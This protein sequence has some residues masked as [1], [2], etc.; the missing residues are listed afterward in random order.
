MKSVCFY[1]RPTGLV[2][3]ITLPLYFILVVVELEKVLTIFHLKLNI[4]PT[5]V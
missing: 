4:M 5:W 1:S 3:I 2:K